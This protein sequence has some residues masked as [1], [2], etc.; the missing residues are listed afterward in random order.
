[1]D[2][3]IFKTEELKN[4]IKTYREKANI[5]KS[6]LSKMIGVSPAYITML[7]N[8]EKTNPSLEIMVKISNALAIPIDELVGPVTEAID[9]YDDLD[10]LKRVLLNKT[11]RTNKE[12]IVSNSILRDIDEM[13][14][15][16]NLGS[17]DIIMHNLAFLLNNEVNSAEILKYY[18]SSKKYDITKLN[19]ETLKDIDRKFSE[20]LELEFFKLNK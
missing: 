13:K 11:Y 15:S 10:N 7:E 17:V 14:E 1:M 16:G 20:I 5:S 8:G 6:N 19:D 2:E 9:P 18:I 3:F 12:K 4:I